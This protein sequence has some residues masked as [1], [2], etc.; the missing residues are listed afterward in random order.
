[1][2]DTVS[3][4]TV[5]S[6]QKWFVHLPMQDSSDLRRLTLKAANC[7]HIPFVGYAVVDFVVGVVQVPAK[8]V[9][10]VK[11]DCLGADQVIIGMT[12]IG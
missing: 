1:M 10:I 3:N 12:V 6:F 8:G 9:V 11:D 2:L 5:F 4:V 7:L